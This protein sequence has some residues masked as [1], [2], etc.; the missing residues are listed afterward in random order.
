MI[1]GV[2]WLE[3]CYDCGYPG[4]E[5]CRIDDGI[6]KSVMAEFASAIVGLAA[7]GAKVGN[8]LYGLIDTLKDAPAEFLA[9]SNEVTDFRSIVSQYLEHAGTVGHKDEKILDCV[10]ENG[11]KI[12]KDI[13]QLVADVVKEKKRG[14][15]PYKVDRVQWLRQVKKAQKLRGLL[16]AQKASIC[17]FLALEI[18]YVIRLAR[19]AVLT[20]EIESRVPSKDCALRASR[21]GSRVSLN[22]NF[23]SERSKKRVSTP[24]KY[25]TEVDRESALL[26]QKN[27]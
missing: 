23:L 14:A 9:L 8:S 2:T 3:A 22:G 12:L 15:E 17:N 7:V 21:P 18:L 25:S 5:R 6:V 16:R 11:G 13:E 19:S 1:G 24:S 20:R 10:R 4:M 27:T 26:S